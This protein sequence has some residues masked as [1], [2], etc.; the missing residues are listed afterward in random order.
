MVG[1][2]FRGLNIGVAPEARLASAL[3]LPGGS[4]SFAQ[5]IAGMQ[6]AVNQ[7]LSGTCPF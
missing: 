1:R 6:W 7:R 4:G 2:T 5:I 3:V